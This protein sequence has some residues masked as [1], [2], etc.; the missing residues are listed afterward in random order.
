MK[1]A[2]FELERWEEEY[3]KGKLKG[4][5]IL[6]FKKPLSLNNVN[7]INDFNII[8]IFVYSKLDAKMLE[9]F[10][11][12]KFIATMSAGFDHIDLEYC[13]KKGIKVSNIPYYGENT[14]AEHTFGLL[15]ALS[16]KIYESIYKTKRDD[17]SI[18]G[19]MGFDLKG[20][21]LGIIGPGRIGQLVIKI[22]KGFEMNIITYA[23]NKNKKLSRELGFKWVSLNDLLNKSDIITI[24]APLNDSTKHMINMNN[25]VKIKK[26]AYLI[27]TARGEIVDTEALVY[28]LDRG[29]IA[30]A[31]LDVLE[32]EY[33]IKEE[34]ELLHL[35][36]KKK[37]DWNTFI[38]NHLLLKE[39]NVIITPH[40]AFYTR[41][42][43]ERILD[44]TIDNIKQ[45]LKGKVSNKVV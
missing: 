40:S 21:T 28:G 18:K 30:G 31:G 24:H 15:L 34:K 29:I 37:Y 32:G 1:I 45:F 22:A 35:H 5:K 16:K 25:V 26:G 10:D 9:K 3:L 39:K 36:F 13:K 8:G 20:K 42:A 7:K 12:L 23:P 33:N 14:V 38:R 17:F 41:E 43:L 11:R 27:N 19:L 4:H 2:F 6:F 44:T